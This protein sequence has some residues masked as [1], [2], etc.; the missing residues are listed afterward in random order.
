MNHSVDFETCRQNMVE[1]QIRTGG[2]VHPGIVEAFRHVPRELFVHPGQTGIAYGDEDLPLAEGRC[3]MEPLTHA[4]LLSFALPVS[5]DTALVVGGATG[6]ASAILSKLVSSVVSVDCFA[7]WTDNARRLWSDLGCQN[8]TAHT[9]DL[10]WGCPEKS[11]YSLIFINGGVSHVPQSLLDQLSIGG[12]LVAVVN[13]KLGV[14]MGQG[15]IIYRTSE[16]NFSERV[17]FD[18]AV[19]CLR[20]FAPRREFAF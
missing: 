13:D 14:M 2:V 1:S 17:L 7:E 9:G 8:I 19:P 5:E 10:V 15:R 11:P 20:E 18:A 16:D 3:L 4:R 12:R 6:Y